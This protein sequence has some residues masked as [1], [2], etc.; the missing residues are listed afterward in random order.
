MP[1]KKL[2][3][4]HELMVKENYQYYDINGSDPDNLL[5]Q[6]REKGTK[7]NDGKVYAALT[8]WD[9][10]YHYDVAEDNGKYSLKSIATDVDIVFHLPKRATPSGTDPIAEM[11]NKYYENLKIHEFGHK[12]L[13]VKAAADINT[14][15]A[16]LGSFDSSKELEE[17]A[18]SLVH[19]KL[20]RLRDVQV[21]YDDETQ[22]GETQGAILR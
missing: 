7:W 10:S 1:Q 15:L 17:R 13:A 16:S 21:D 20:K 9:I 5:H 2:D 14:S 18:K 11:W 19:E 8:T 4:S 22:H 3:V 6:M 12:D